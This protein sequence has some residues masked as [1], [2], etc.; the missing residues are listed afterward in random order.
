M[1]KLTILFIA[2]L[3]MLA[4]SSAYAQDKIDFKA[5]GWIDAQTLWYR[6][7]TQ[8]NT[9]SG[10]YNTVPADYKYGGAAYNRTVGFLE[11]R[12]RLR[13]D[14]AYG[15][16]INGTMLFEMDA[17]PWGNSPGGSAAKISERNTMGYWSGDRAA[18]EIK[19][20]YFDWA[21][22]SIPVPV[23]MRVGLQPLSIRPNILVY[24]DGMGIIAGFKVDPVLIQPIWFKAVEG[25]SWTADDVDIYGLNVNAKIGTMTVGGYGLYY[26]MN[27]YPLY[28]PAPTI[29]TNQADMWWFGVYADGKAGPVNLNFDFIYDRGTVE[30]KGFSPFFPE[31]KYRGWA[32]RVAFDFPMEQFNF[33]FV[34][35]Y[36]SGA[37]TQKTSSTGAPGSLTSTGVATTKVG[38]YVTPPG[39]ESGTNFGE[40]V[41]FYNSW[42]N[43]GSSGI[44]TSN[45]YNSMCR[46]PIGGTWM[47]KLYAA[48]KAT[49]WYKATFQVLYIGDTTKNGNTF[50]TA[51]AGPIPALGTRDDKSIGFEFDL[52][53]E[54]QIY[55]NLKYVIGAGYLFAGKAMDFG[56]LGTGPLAGL[57]FNSKPKDPWQITT[58]LT[59]NF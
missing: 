14:W 9:S 5:S 47:A 22:P 55:K 17:G 20:V 51:Y 2:G 8:G 36:A 25:N 16:S 50:G 37:D 59:Y 11:S 19:N 3:F 57:A 46:G 31:V 49:P 44:A 29:G 33:G 1:R 15:K 18:V 26:N 21:V 4:F 43:R 56:Y 24:T 28:N 45:N 34:G 39:S 30:R 54:I 7:V 13:F 12:A 41:V 6:N 35:V 40:S 38:S 42:I 10:I 53:Q 58:N 48:V 52:I 23:N 27:S 32:T